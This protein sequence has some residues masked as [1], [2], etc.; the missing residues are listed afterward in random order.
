MH[1]DNYR[2]LRHTVGRK[3]LTVA[4]LSNSRVDG[5]DLNLKLKLEK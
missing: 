4:V 5:I 3:K 2:Q 1:G